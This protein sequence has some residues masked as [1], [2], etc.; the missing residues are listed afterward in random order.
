MDME[1]RDVRVSVGMSLK[2]RKRACPSVGV[3]KIFEPNHETVE[4][5]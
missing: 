2:V 4:P 5:N 1:D 3:D